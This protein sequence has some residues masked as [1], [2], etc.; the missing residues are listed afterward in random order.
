MRAAGDVYLRRRA[1]SSPAGAWASRSTSTRW[2][3][4]QMITNLLMLRGNIGRP[5]A[6]SCPVRG[7]S[8]VQGDRTMG[9]WEKPPAALL[10]RLRDVFGFEPP[11]AP[12][13]D[14][15]ES[16]K[17]MLRRPRQG[18]HRARRQLRRRPR[19]TPTRPGRRCASCDLTVH[20]TTKLNR[21]HLVHG[22]RR[23]DPALPGPHR[24]RRAGRRPAGRDGGGFDEHGAHLVAASTRRR[25][26]TC[27]PSRRSSRAWPPRRWARAAGRRGCG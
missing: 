17:L 3:T 20:V 21:S 25:P 5:G 11:R 8:N 15:V 7:H 14:V 2:R 10:D 23:A 18:V 1:A 27:C 26:S 6:G 24:D 12:G 22:A 19:P 4:I 13:V 9:I 16:I